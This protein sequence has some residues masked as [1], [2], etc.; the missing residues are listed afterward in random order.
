MAADPA[1]IE[2][3]V[4]GVVS[5]APTGTTAPTDSTTA[6]NVAFTD[7]GEIGE[8]GVTE[9]WDDSQT[10][11]K[12]NAG[13]TVRRI[14]SETAATIHFV[15]LETKSTTLELYYKG[16]TVTGS[17]PYSIDIQQPQADPRSF[18]L[19]TLDGSTHER[20]Y[21]PSGEVTERGEISYAANGA[22]QYEVTITCY[23][24]SSGT[25][26]KKFS[27]SAAWA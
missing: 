21:I 27:D 3:A 24:D 2:V 22:K 25:I 23:P 8:D 5:V 15:M 12:N 16:S 6:L 13:V 10:D 18:V 11:V 17:G 19:D 4:S 14:L 20:M 26:A 9:A 7:V 1:N